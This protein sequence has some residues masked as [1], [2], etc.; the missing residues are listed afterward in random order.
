MS[1]VSDV[2]RFQPICAFEKMRATD[3]QRLDFIC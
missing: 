2:F 1:F 3:K